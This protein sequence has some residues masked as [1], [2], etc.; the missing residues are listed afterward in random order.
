MFEQTQGTA[1]NRKRKNEPISIEAQHPI[2]KP[3]SFSFT[4]NNSR[5]LSRIRYHF[6]P[7]KRC[8][9]SKL[10]PVMSLVL[11]PNPPTCVT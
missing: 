7:P 11:R 10:Y 3:Y 2:W 6:L 4:I 8:Q 1:E 9:S 5:A